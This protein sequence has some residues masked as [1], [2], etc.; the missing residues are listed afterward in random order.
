MASPREEKYLEE[1]YYA[2]QRTGYTS[3]TEIAL[4]LNVSLPSVS[5]M[6]QK[7]SKNE[8]L[9]YKP[10][11]K[12]SMTKKGLSQGEKL[13]YHHQVLEDFFQLIELN[14]EQIPQEIANI[15]YRIS[16]NAVSKIKDFLKKEKYNNR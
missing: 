8:Y 12:I 2:V 3:V 15:E 11:G 13:A 9:L 5:K 1:I 6:V 14:Q 16:E 4:S 10:Y 7:L